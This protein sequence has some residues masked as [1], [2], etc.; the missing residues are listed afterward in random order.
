MRAE[1]VAKALLDRGLHAPTIYFPLVVEEALM[2]EFTESEP[3]RM[4][5]EYASALREIAEQAY[6]DPEPLRRAPTR[7]S[8][9]RLDA[10]YANHPR[11]VTP[12]H[13]VKRRRE[14]G[15]KLTL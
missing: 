4:I 2:I 15:E 6:R 14:R 13:R 12:S 10:V 3:R 7:T 9:G 1:D 5:E 8:V 11:T